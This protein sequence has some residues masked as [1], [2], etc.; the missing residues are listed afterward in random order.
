MNIRHTNV[1]SIPKAVEADPFTAIHG[2]GA[3]IENRLHSAGILTYRQL[4][5]LEPEEI[6]S[7]LGNLVGMTPKRVIDQDWKGQA[8][9]LSL[10]SSQDQ[11]PAQDETRQHYE[12]FSVEL[13]LDELNQVRR[14]KIIH[15]QS[16]AEVSWAGWNVQRLLDTIIKYAE[17]RQV[18]I[19]NTEPERRWEKLT[20]SLNVKTGQEADQ[21]AASVRG[22]LS[23]KDMEVL[24]EGMTKPSSIIRGDQSYRINLTLDMSSVDWPTGR[25]LEY[26]ATIYARDL[27]QAGQISIGQA[28]GMVSEAEKLTIQIEGEVIPVGIYRL[29]AIVALSNQ[30]HPTAQGSGLVAMLEAGLLQVY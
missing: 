2:I 12:M 23:L 14:T 17:L 30:G 1:P 26:T 13:L 20:G 15:S 11:T 8:Q 7:A 5:E 16:K 21:K 27:D 6:A 4:A 3:G 9:K 22:E 24:M 19:A 29:E 25:A 28:R 10:E 18:P